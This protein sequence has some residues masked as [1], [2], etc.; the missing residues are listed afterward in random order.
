VYAAFS[1]MAAQANGDFGSAPG[2]FAKD[3]TGD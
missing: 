2:A 3:G 1:Y